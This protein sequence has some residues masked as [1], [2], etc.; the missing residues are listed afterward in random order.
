M[1]NL[2]SLMGE[3]LSSKITAVDLAS[4]KKVTVDLNDHTISSSFSHRT[5]DNYIWDLLYLPQKVPGINVCRASELEIQHL[6]TIASS[7]HTRTPVNGYRFDQLF[8]DEAVAEFRG[9]DGLALPGLQIN[10]AEL[11]DGD[12]ARIV[13]TA[14]PD[15][16]NYHSY[17]VK[18]QK[19]YIRFV[20]LPKFAIWLAGCFSTLCFYERTAEA[21]RNAEANEFMRK[22]GET[23][24]SR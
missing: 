21:R 4:G 6:L 2:D 18:D 12:Y 15:G 5:P 11:D 14:T 8:P 13:V 19:R 9:E 7:G 22:L 24:A 1:E 10:P 23:F 17:T 3:L 20:L 16:S